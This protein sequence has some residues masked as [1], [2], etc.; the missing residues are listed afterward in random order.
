M[1][2]ATVVSTAVATCIVASV[3]AGCGSDNA[4]DADA[5]GEYY[6]K[7]LNGVY[8]E[9]EGSDLDDAPWEWDVD[10]AA[11][12]AHFDEALE[13][14]PDHCGALLGSALCHALLAATDPELAEILGELFPP[15]ER[16]SSGPLLWYAG[17]PRPL[18][19][20]GRVADTREEFRFS[21][22]Q[23]Y[24]E[25]DALPELAIAEDRLT[26]FEALDC[27]LELVVSLPDSGGAYPTTMV[28]EVDVTDAY[29]VHA[30]LDALEAACRCLS[31]YDVDVEDGQ[32]LYDLIET[33]GEFLTLRSGS[34]AAA[35]FQELGGLAARLQLAA[36]SLSEESDQQSNDV[37]TQTGGLIELE[38]LIGDD[39]VGV[40]NQLGEDIADALETGL[41]LSPADV[42]PSA[43]EVVVVVDLNELLND[44]LTDV[45]PLL[46]EH[47]WPSPDS[48]RFSEPI[49]MPDPTLDGITPDMS[50]EDWGPIV[51]WLNGL[52]TSQPRDV[53]RNKAR[54]P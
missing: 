40:L 23:Q 29:F 39:P 22:L 49:T 48:I 3:L 50:D 9:L 4:T 28:V 8:R 51:L 54:N 27:E 31:V 53:E 30:A 33:D 45:R 18:T 44:P 43:P 5:A 6:L 20:L 34:H 11:P 13:L 15:D 24:L 25:T 41:E 36:D 19:L 2:S 10:L 35:A 52:R 1:R 47:D 21:R 26:R 7:G 38:E 16:R 14:D 46:P 42:D 12:A 37:V 32:T 17:G